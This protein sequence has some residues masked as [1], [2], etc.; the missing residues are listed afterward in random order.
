MTKSQ[1]TSIEKD[2]FWL[3]TD[4]CEFFVTFEQYPAFQ[5]ATIEQ[6]FNF[7][8]HFRDFYWE[9][10]DI[11]IELDALKNPGKYPLKFK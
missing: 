11:D 5:K 10:L 4:D 8:E 9:E 7:R 2:G 6:I 1:I 3:L